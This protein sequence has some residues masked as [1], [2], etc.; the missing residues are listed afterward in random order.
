MKKI[1][2]G[3]IAIGL[4][5]IVGCEK[6]KQKGC[7]DPNAINFD[8][9]AE[10][11]DGSCRHDAAS[12]L[13][14]L[15][16]TT[17]SSIT[18]TKA[19]SGG[20]ITNGGDTVIFR[21]VCWSTSPNP[22]IADYSL[23]NGNGTGSFTVNLT[24]LKGGTTYYV[25]AYAINSA[26]TSYGNEV[27]FTTSFSFDLSTVLENVADNI[28]IPQFEALKESITEL[29]SAYT[30]FESSG[31]SENLI[32]FQEKFKNSYVLWQS[33]SFVNYGNTNLIYLGGI[34]NTYPTDTV[35]I[36]SIFTKPDAN[37]ESVMYFDAIGFPGL[38]Y[39]LFEGSE[40]E[41]ID[42][43]SN[44]GSLYCSKNIALIKTKVEEAYTFWKDDADGFYSNFKTQTSKSV[45]SPF[46]ALVN[47]F[48]KDAE[49]F[50]NN[51]LGLPAGKFTFNNPHPDQSEALYSGISI[52]LYK[53][54]L[55]N[56]ER[57]YKGQDLN[58]TDG[59]GLD[60]Y[61]KYLGATIEL[62]D[63]TENLN[64]LILGT[65]NTLKEK[66]NLLTGTMNE[67]I[68][69]QKDIIDELYSKTKELVVYLK[70]DMTY[71]F[72]VMIMYSENDAG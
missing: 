32:N 56:L 39:V 46:S 71:A 59:L 68:E 38:D 47:G 8:S 67:A 44:A 51:Q 2:Y 24:G 14:T 27:S 69:N 9:A 12:S 48:I 13:P 23:A 6:E 54:H 72:D 15:T 30:I 34:L 64:E 53:E 66:S 11:N 35:N 18:D 36:N 28:I 63:A 42:R 40:E 26:G 65:F 20:N 7:T 61:L 60:D 21:G 33:C 22:T 49:L 62:N 43:I 45:G 17:V 41:I 16:T 3:F 4:F 31:T 29:E 58:G 57:L 5:T 1:L 10:E 25:R 37:L 50:K 19:V 52:Q 55:A 70:V